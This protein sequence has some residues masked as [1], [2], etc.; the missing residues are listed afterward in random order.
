MAQRMTQRMIATDGNGR[1]YL[2]FCHEA[3][4]YVCGECAP[5]IVQPIMQ[6]A[7]VGAHHCA[8]SDLILFLHGM[9]LALLSRRQL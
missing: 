8:K 5:C 7:S 1:W 4:V 3:G 9:A 2:L 6:Y